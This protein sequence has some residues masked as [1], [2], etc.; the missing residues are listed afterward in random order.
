LVAEPF[1]SSAD[2]AQKNNLLSDLIFKDHQR[3]ANVRA[4]RRLLVLDKHIFI[5]RL[6][7][8]ATNALLRLRLQ[9]AEAWTPNGLCRKS[10]MKLKF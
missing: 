1:R 6:A 3:A 9:H 5:F 4:A 8:E 10:E 7:A 2:I